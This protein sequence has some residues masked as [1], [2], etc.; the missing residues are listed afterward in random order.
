MNS[1]STNPWQSSSSSTYPNISIPFTLINLL[2]NK[3]KGGIH[4]PNKV[5]SLAKKPRLSLSSE[6]K[7]RMGVQLE[8]S[9]TGEQH[10]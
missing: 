2:P 3:W 7:E 10:N 1:I 5:D 6:V 9:H 8:R 4:E